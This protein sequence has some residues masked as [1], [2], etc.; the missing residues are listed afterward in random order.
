MTARHAAQS[1]MEPLYQRIAE[2]EH[3]IE[4]LQAQLTMGVAK[5]AE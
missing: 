5:W 3:Q 4:N 2:L 1:E